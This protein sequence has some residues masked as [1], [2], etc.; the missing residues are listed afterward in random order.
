MTNVVVSGDGEGGGRW[1]WDPFA[2][3]PL[4]ATEH[5]GAWNGPRS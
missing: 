3:T 4:N 1:I 2:D 5:H